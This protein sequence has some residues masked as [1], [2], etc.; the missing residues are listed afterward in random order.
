MVFKFIEKYIRKNASEFPKI[1]SSYFQ[2]RTFSYNVDD[3]GRA[4]ELWK[5]VL[6]NSP[7]YDKGQLET[8][9]NN[10]HDA[11]MYQA[12]ME[13]S[14]RFFIVVFL[15]LFWVFMWLEEG[16]DNVDFSPLYDEKYENNIYA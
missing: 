16:E 8:E 13:A 1:S 14:K 15:Y 10:L 4:W 12:N 11:L 9:T 3:I 6:E 2:P 5:W 7:V